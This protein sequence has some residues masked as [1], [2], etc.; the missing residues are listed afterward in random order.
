M[1]ETNEI[2]TCKRCG[3]EV[4]LMTSA[5]SGKKFYCNS[6]EPK[7]WHSKTCRPK[8]KV[9]VTEQGSIMVTTHQPEG[10]LLAKYEEEV[11]NT[12]DR[13]IEIKD[14]RRKIAKEVEQEGKIAANIMKS[15]AAVQ[16]FMNETT[17]DQMIITLLTQIRDVMISIEEQLKK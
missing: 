11:K 5:M 2:T 16:S 7:D 9:E 12:K 3:Q 1:T 10:N 6:E 4:Y 8:P 14:H 15:A 17:T 13:V